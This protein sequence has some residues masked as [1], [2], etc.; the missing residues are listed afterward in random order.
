MGLTKK[1]QKVNAEAKA[2]HL[3]KLEKD[4]KLFKVFRAFKVIK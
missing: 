3:L 1:E 2:K 4:L